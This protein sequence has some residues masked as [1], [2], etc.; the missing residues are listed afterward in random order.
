MLV[1]WIAHT[2]IAVGTIA[3]AVVIFG[4][5][6]DPGKQLMSLSLLV[7]GVF[8]HHFWDELIRDKGA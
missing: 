8:L 6:A 5:D 1:R 7:A 2:L 4:M 3:W